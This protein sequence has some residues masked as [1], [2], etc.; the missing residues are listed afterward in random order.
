MSRSWHPIPEHQNEAVSGV[1]RLAGPVGDASIAASDHRTITRP[2]VGRFWW[3]PTRVTGRAFR[4]L[5]PPA[6]GLLERRLE[7]AVWTPVWRVIGRF[8]F[9]GG[10]RVSSSLQF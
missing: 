8:A 6:Q 5:V 1:P 2:P 3:P 10:V 7:D 4:M 9:Q